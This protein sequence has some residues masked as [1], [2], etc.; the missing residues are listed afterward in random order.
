MI[1]EYEEIRLELLTLEK[2]IN[3]LGIALDIEGAKEAVKK[4]EEESLAPDFYNDMKNSQKVLQK[5]KEQ[6]TKIERFNALKTDWEDISTLVE[7]AIAEDDDTLLGEITEG[8]EK[9]CANLETMKLQTLLS[10]PYDKNNAIVTLHPGAGGTE[11]QDTEPSLRFI[12]F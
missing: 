11:S 6:N 4:L 12:M 1:V 10:G 2:P 7:L 9:L 5:I 8:Y 3:E